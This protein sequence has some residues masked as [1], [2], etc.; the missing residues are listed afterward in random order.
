MDYDLYTLDDFLMDDLFLA[1]CQGSDPA[2]VIFWE[3][4]QSAKPP[5]LNAFREAQ[6]L[7]SLLNG[8]KP[9]LDQALLELETLIRGEQQTA[10]IVPM[11]V[12]AATP[13]F[14]WWA[15]AASVLLVVGLGW[16]GFDAWS[17]QY[18]TYKTAYNEQRTID[19][20]DGSVVVLNSHSLLKHRRNAFS[21]GERAV[22]IEGEG[23]FTVRHLQT[24]A[25]FRVITNR[26]FDVQVLGTEFSIYNRP[27]RHRVVLNTGR[28]RVQFYDK[29]SA[30]MLQPGQLVELDGHTQQVQKRTVRA[31][32]YNAWLRDQLV[33]DNTSLTEAIQIVEEQFGIRVQLDS[34]A[35][36]KRTVT[37]ILPINKPEAV[38]NAI[39]GL[40]QLE[41][42]KRGES[43]YLI[44][45]RQPD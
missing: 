29:Q 30:L 17:N 27:A 43:F 2:A 10:K 24:N 21:S 1:Y 31:D 19:L 7:F 16:M 23:F 5:N 44:G 11:P 20:P 14:T 33:F 39:A 45:K 9:R 6:Q 4:W 25:P 26:A 35:L 22:E 3:R 40:T 34:A 32:Q 15:I 37:G 41:V 38:L 36:A 42:I 12:A 28:V 18:I 13:R 8:Q